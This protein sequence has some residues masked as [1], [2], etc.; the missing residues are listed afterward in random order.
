MTIRPSCSRLPTRLGLGR[1]SVLVLVELSRDDN[2]QRLD[3][4]DRIGSARL[5]V[6]TCTSDGG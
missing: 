4:L 2:G 3:G 1:V 5:Q 6:E